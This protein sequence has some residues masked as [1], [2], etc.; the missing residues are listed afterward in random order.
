MPFLKAPF[1][2]KGV[3][4]EKTEQQGAEYPEKEERMM[5][6]RKEERKRDAVGILWPGARSCSFQPSNCMRALW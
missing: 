2:G 5:R 1:D 6:E 3:E 4:K